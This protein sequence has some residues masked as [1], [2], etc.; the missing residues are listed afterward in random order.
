MVVA[1]I[2]AFGSIYS[3][4]FLRYSYLVGQLAGPSSLYAGLVLIHFFIPGFLLGTGLAPD[5]VNPAHYEYLSLALCYSILGLFAVQAGAHVFGGVGNF[6]I[7]VEQI[8]I[9]WCDYTLAIISIL[10]LAV[11]WIDRIYVIASDGYIQFKRSSAEGIDGPFAAAIRMI[12]LFPFYVLCIVSIRFWRPTASP[13]RWAI[14]LYVLIAMEIAYWA[15]SGR[16]EPIILAI[17][18]PFITRYLRIQKLPS[19]ILSISFVLFIFALLPIA[20]YYR[21]TLET[22]GNAADASSLTSAANDALSSGGNFNL[23]PSEI[24]FGRLSLV[25]PLA[26]CIRLWQEDIWAPMYG[27]SYWNAIVSIIPRFLWLEKPDFHYGND[28]GFVTGYLSEADYAT[29]I[30]ITFFGESILNFGLAGLMPLFMMG[31]LFSW[32]LRLTRK[33]ARKE[34][35]LLLYL[36]AIPT[37]LY[38]GGSF[39]LYFGGLIK[40]LPFF[41]VLGR[42]MEFGKSSKSTQTI[43]SER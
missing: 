7:E 24:L 35:W 34:T 25:E 2:S 9:A 1:I 12:E 23:T 16:K 28:F 18:I 37:I 21:T 3:I 4:A 15:P 10:L 32:P 6:I 40:L 5:F 38:I 22:M 36:I 31:V 11:G 17:L 13:R 19:R 42:I 29:S 41:Y 39:A 43:N 20:F 8:E 30:S 33:S 14:A 26:A 27:S